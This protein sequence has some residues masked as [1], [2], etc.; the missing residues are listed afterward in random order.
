MVAQ[1]T[2]HRLYDPTLRRGM[3]VVQVRTGKARLIRGDGDQSGPVWSPDGTRI[4]YESVSCAADGND[5]SQIFV[6][7]V[8]TGESIPM[9]RPSPDY[10]ARNCPTARPGSCRAEKACLLALPA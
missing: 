10:R 1:W 2:P 6:Y 9:T 7:L 3:W 5:K 4:A 8:K